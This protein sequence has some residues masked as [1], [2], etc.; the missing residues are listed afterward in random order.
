MNCNNE[1]VNDGICNHNEKCMNETVWTTEQ[2]RLIEQI[3]ADERRKVIDELSVYI[4]N[5]CKDVKCKEDIT[6]D[7]DFDFYASELLEMLE[8]LKSRRKENKN[9]EF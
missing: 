8:Q 7:N 3:R 4:L 9:D 2:M 1:C 6:I 5:S